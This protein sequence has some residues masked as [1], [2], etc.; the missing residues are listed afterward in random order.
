METIRTLGALVDNRNE[1]LQAPK[2]ARE[3]PAEA[4]RTLEDWELAMAGGGEFD[5][6]W[7]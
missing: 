3:Q 6:D 5:A 4:L 2:F 1:Q 7:R